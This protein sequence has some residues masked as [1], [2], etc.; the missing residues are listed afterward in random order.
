M[1][2]E[3]TALPGVGLVLDRD[4]AAPMHQQLYEQLRWSIEVGQLQASTRLP[5]TRTLARELGV[6]RN[7]VLVAYDRLQAE[8]Y[9]DGQVG[10]GTR[11]ADRS[12][13]ISPHNE[14]YSPEPVIPEARQPSRPPR[15]SQVAQRLMRA[16]QL[17]SAVHERLRYPERPFTL[18]IPALDL[19]PGKI[20]AEIIGRRC[21][22]LTSAQY[23]HR[24]PAG[25]WPLRRE[26]AASV[27]LMRGVRCTADQVI[28]EPSAQ[29]A[30]HLITTVLCDPGEQA[31]VESPGHLA[32]R[33][34][35]TATGVQAC[36]VDVDGEGL[37]IKMGAT[38]YPNAR[39]VSV[40]PNNQF[41]LAIRM[42]DSR[43]NELFEWTQANDGWIIEDD[44]DGEFWSDKPSL[45]LHNTD[46]TGRVIYVGT[47]SKVMFPGI[48]LAYM[49]APPDLVDALTAA[50]RVTVNSLNLLNQAA[51]VDFINDN[52]FAR[53]VRRMREAYTERRLACSEALR[54]HLGDAISFDEPTAGMH[55]VVRLNHDIDEAKVAH[56]SRQ[57]HL[58]VYPLSTFHLGDS[59]H[60]RGLVLGYGATEP[61]QLA[62]GAEQLAAI[63][64]RLS[65]PGSRQRHRSTP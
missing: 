18:G 44:Y 49:V 45:P 64:E 39:L 3:S 7:T 31:L 29:V 57:A 17:F 62:A 28:I 23:S 61:K 46:P 56:L 38:R 25:Y 4:S 63:V 9:L 53:H 60:G 35:I 13:F 6:S 30:V 47:F 22:R 24:D 26:I 43:R 33:A 32:T 1:P 59:A 14:T 8:G 10:S 34:A 36:G 2:R 19:F 16:S 20:W 37:R 55:M 50:H 41:P 54:Q 5:A 48:C 51:L 15:I 27:G 65:R 12:S 21:Y 52:H 11:V 58:R 42:S 40:T